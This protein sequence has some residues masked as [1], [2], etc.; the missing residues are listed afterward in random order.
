VSPDRSLASELTTEDPE[1][2][3]SDRESDPTH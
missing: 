2:R 1:L 3:D